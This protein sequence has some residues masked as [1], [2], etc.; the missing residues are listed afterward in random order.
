MAV[1]FLGLS[2]SQPSLAECTTNRNADIVITKPDSRYSDHGDGT[3]TDNETGLMW[4]ACSLG[5][6]YNTGSCDGATSTMN[7]QAALTAANDNTDFGHDDWILPNINQLSSLTET[8]CD[9]PSIN[10]SLFPNTRSSAFW[11]ATPSANSNTSSSVW[12]VF[13]GG[14]GTS[15]KSA[16]GTVRL[17][18]VSQ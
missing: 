11:S 1:S 7:W 16:L 5:Q 18:R 13:A 2:L 4:Q 8:A 3:V 12:V 10:E 15:P 9:R 17:V 6:T 14:E